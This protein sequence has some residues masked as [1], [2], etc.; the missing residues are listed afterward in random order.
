ME[1]VKT[2]LPGVVLIKPNVIEDERG[3]FM[4]SYKR[5]EF[6]KYGITDE[7]IQDNHSCSNYAVLR[8]LHYQLNPYSQAKL[9]RC[10]YGKVFDVAVDIR[11]NS[12][13]FAKWVAYELSAANKWLL[14]IPDGFAHGFVTLSESAELNYKVTNEYAKDCECGIK[15]DDSMINIAWP[16]LA[17]DYILSSK[18]EQQPSLSVA[19]IN[20][21][22]SE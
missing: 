10:T 11:R 19:R 17:T 13:T 5:S 1:F 12:P 9:V 20:F 2:A 21:E 22:Y 14:Y 8:G 7:F 16:K 18:D 4:E 6:V 15:F 3:F